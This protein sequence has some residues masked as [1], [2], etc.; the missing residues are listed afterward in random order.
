MSSNISL[1]QSSEILNMTEDEVMFEKQQGN[2]QAKVDEDTMAWVF[3]LN[4]VLKLKE[5]VDKRN[6]TEEEELEDE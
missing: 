1:K 4:D 3:S 5:Q 6:D 2:I